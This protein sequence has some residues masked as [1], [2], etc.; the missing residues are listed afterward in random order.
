MGLGRPYIMAVSSEGPGK[1]LRHPFRHLA[2]LCFSLAFLLAACNSEIASEPG[3]LLLAPE[4]LQGTAITVISESQ[5][6]SVGGPSAL[7]ELQGPGYRVLQSL[8]LFESRERALSALD[9]I[10]ADLVSRGES[11]PGAPEASG[12]IEHPLGNEDAVSLFFIE[13]RGLVRLTVTGP[14]R[15]SRLAELSAI[16]REKISGG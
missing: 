1:L 11:G 14:D 2:A 6:Q 15:D 8:V 7:V 9:G 10:R 12:I 4:D 3:E 16:A 13:N 5:Q